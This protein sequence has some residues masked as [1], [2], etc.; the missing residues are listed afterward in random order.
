[1][2]LTGNDCEI[3]A[4]ALRAWTEGGSEAESARAI[5]LAE[6]IERSVEVEITLA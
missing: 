1:M 3:I 5:E 4:L 6:A 2:I